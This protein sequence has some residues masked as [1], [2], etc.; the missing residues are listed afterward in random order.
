MDI[1]LS[2]ILESDAFVYVIFSML[3]GEQVAPVRSLLFYV[4]L[5]EVHFCI[6]IYPPSSADDSIK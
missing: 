3:S 1:Q 2:K 5:H 4:F 6:L